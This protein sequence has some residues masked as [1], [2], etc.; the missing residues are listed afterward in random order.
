MP[1]LFLY[2]AAINAATF[3]T[4]AYDK[5]AARKRKR[6]IRERTLHLLA[7]LGGSPAALVAQQL[8]RHKNAKRSFQLIFWGLVLLQVSAV[9]WMM[10]S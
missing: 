4:Y 6:R 2:L 3:F 7:L 9:T 1:Y 5:R 10:L 8:F